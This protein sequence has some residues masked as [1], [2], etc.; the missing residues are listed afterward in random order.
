VLAEQNMS[1][2]VYR[3]CGRQEDTYL[4][5]IRPHK[6]LARRLQFGREFFT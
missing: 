1:L 5:P 3:Y 2:S 4:R 6:S